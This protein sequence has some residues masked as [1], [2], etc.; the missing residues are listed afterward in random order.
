M[1]VMDHKIAKRNQETRDA[2]L[3][4]R[5]EEDEKEAEADGK[6][7]TEKSLSPQRDQHSDLISI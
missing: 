6:K 4:S 5:K 3:K 2:M 7:D 1:R